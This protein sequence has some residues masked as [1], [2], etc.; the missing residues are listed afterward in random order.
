M[1]IELNVQPVAYLIT[2]IFTQKYG[3][4]IFNKTLHYTIHIIN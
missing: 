2:L 4:I 1:I 3:A